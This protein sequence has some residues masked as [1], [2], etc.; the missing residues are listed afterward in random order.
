MPKRKLKYIGSGDGGQIKMQVWQENAFWSRICP[1]G[2]E[3]GQLQE[4][5]GHV[6]VQVWRKSAKRACENADMLINCPFG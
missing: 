3:S 6:K 1:L 5:I 4:K 2:S